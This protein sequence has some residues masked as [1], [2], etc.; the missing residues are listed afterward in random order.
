MFETIH[1]YLLNIGSN[2]LFES[3][4]LSILKKLDLNQECKNVDD[5][6]LYDDVIKMAAKTFSPK[7]LR[8]L[9]D[10]TIGRDAIWHCPVQK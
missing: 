2:V 3:I 9:N 5:D 7:A 4:N 8:P 6:K 10:T 1:E